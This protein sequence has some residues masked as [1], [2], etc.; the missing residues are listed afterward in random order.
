MRRVK[1]KVYKTV[2]KPEMMW[3]LESG[4][5]EKINRRMVEL[6]MLRFLLGYQ[7]GQIRGTAQVERFGGKT[8]EK[9]G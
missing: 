6:K 9:N 2:V 1:E 4:A 3:D 5:L 8:L 7:N